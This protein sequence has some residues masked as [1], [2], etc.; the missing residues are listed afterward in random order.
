L[1]LLLLLRLLLMVLKIRAQ[2]LRPR[3]TQKWRHLKLSWW[4]TPA[5][6]PQRSTLQLHLLLLLLAAAVAS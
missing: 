3:L 1:L 6:T 4:A 5:V 2:A